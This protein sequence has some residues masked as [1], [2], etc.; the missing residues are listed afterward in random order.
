MIFSEQILDI[1]YTSYN[2]D[3]AIKEE[4]LISHFNYCNKP[5]SRESVKDIVYNKYKGMGGYREREQFTQW[6]FE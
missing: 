2:G 1:V 5:Y 3:N 4:K 6:I